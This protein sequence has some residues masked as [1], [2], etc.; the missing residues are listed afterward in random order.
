MGH[1]SHVDMIAD[2]YGRVPSKLAL[3]KLQMGLAAAA[4]VPHTA[5]SRFLLP[6]PGPANIRQFWSGNA[7][8]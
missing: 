1:D 3:A 7:R 5:W 2:K 8:I 6:A 4:S